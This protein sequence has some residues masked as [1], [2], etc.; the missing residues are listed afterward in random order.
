MTLR[1]EIWVGGCAIGALLVLSWLTSWRA[2]DAAA[3]RLSLAYNGSQPFPAVVGEAI[4]LTPAVS[5]SIKSY[6]VRPDLPSGLK[7]NHVTGVISGTPIKPSNP[8]IF[9]VTAYYRGGHS[10]YALVLGVTEPPS[11]LSYPSPARGIVGTNI[12]PL[13]PKIAGAAKHYSVTP[14]LPAGMELD[15]VS[16][17]I[18]GNPERA[19][20][21]APY[22]VTASS[23]AGSTSFVFWFAVLEPSPAG[24]P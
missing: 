16:G 22:S 19:T 3:P 8:A 12:T 10:S 14:A 4:S 1:G 17:V 13:R 9:T 20:Q 18:K 11:H 5:G 23:Q 2:G 15:G 24:N 6:A 7:L 21:L